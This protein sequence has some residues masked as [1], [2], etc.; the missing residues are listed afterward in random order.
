VE[1]FGVRNEIR[2]ITNFVNCERYRPDTAKTAASLYAPRGEFLLIHVSNFRPVKRAADCVRVLAELRR[3][4]PARLLMVGDGPDRGPAERLAREL[5]VEEDVLF[6]GK[7]NHVE[8]LIPLA[9]VLLMPS[10]MESFGLVALEAMACG[11]V[12]VATRVGGVPELITDGEN[13]FL[14]SVGD[15]P[16]MAVRVEQLL[17]DCKLHYRMSMSGR[18]TATEQFCTDRV[19][20]QYEQY[21]R[22]VV[23]AV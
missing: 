4:I 8:R 12:P 19:I 1:V 10:E 14:E 20:P 17:S 6:L 5:K 11:V 3:R 13:G 15:I 22:D 18:W 21:Y 16:S 23:Q 7:Q 9:H 2:V